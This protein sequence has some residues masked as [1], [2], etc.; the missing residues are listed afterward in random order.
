MNLSYTLPSLSHSFTPES[1][2][3]CKGEVPC[4]R[5]QHQTNVPILRGEKHDISCL[6]PHG[7]QRLW[8]NATLKPLSHVLPKAPV[9]TISVLTWKVSSYCPLALRGITVGWSGNQDP[10]V[11]KDPVNFV[12]SGSHR[13][14]RRS[15]ASPSWRVALVYSCSVC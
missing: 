6:K 3:A 9:L 4:P 2:E 13:V 12:C 7:G 10:V 11:L 14:P 8:Q 1:S 15:V 5:T